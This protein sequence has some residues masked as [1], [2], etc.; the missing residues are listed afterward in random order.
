ME[1]L[2]PLPDIFT[3]LFDHLEPFF[4]HRQIDFITVN[5]YEAGQGIMPHTDSVVSF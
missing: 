4:G 3:K 1:K 2:D 5:E